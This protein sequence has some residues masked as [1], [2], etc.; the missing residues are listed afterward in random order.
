[1]PGHRATRQNTG[2]CSCY[3]LLFP[4]RRE[5]FGLVSE[6]LS[7]QA[8]DA[9]HG[10]AI[11]NRTLILIWRG[12]VSESAMLATNNAA[13]RFVAE[14][15]PASCLFIVE[16]GSPPP[17]GTAR[18]AL[19]TFSREIAAQMVLAVVVAEGGG[20]RAALVRGVGLALRPQV[21]IRERE[22]RFGRLSG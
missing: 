7:L 22:F 18:K 14:P 5:T 19:A 15:G 3:H 13:R 21:E 11:W 9:D 2:S 1:M 12:R 20:F 8:V 16:S 4:R 10:V 17:E 6:R